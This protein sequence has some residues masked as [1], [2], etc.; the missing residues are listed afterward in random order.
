[1]LELWRMWITSLLPSLPGPLCL[2]VVAPER[3]LSMGQIELNCFDI[4]VLIKK[5]YLYETGLFEIDMF[6]DI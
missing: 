4:G 6:F 5:L 1:M 3:E 2:G